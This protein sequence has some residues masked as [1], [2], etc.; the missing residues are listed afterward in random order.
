MVEAPKRIAGSGRRETRKSERREAIVKI[1]RR[2][3]ME[4]GYDRTSMSTIAREMGGSKGTLW[5]YFRSKEA[6]FAAVLDTATAE[7]RTVMTAA[8]DRSSD[9]ESALTRFCDTFID[10][11]TAADAIAL[12]RLI[13]GEVARFPELGR[14]FYERAPGESRN[15]MTAYLADKMVEGRLRVGVPEQ[16]SGCCSRCA[17]EGIINASSGVLSNQTLEQ[18]SARLSASSINFSAVT[19]WIDLELD[20]R[21]AYVDAILPDCRRQSRGLVYS[22]WIGWRS[23]RRRYLHLPAERQR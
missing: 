14:I 2:S 13:V 1:A 23:V 16:A 5:S 6:L 7:F 21:R 9:L 15:I 4:H 17:R 11:I 18:R 12:Q 19:A 8:L 3:F 10:R 22:P 20:R